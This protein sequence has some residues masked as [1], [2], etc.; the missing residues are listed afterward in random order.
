MDE[1]DERS[2]SRLGWGVL[3]VIAVAAL[4][5]VVYL[6]VLG[7]HGARM[8][9]NYPRLFAFINHRQSDR[10]PAAPVA[11]DRHMDP[12]LESDLRGFVPTST[13][14]TVTVRSGDRETLAFAQEIVAWLRANGWQHVQGVSE[15]QRRE[16]KPLTGTNL[17]VNPKGGMELIIG[18]RSDSAP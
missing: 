11:E 6:A 4:A 9:A 7:L 16:L 8:E 1:S 2:S 5:G 10:A 3:A 14:I 18:P 15:H 17:Q 13:S 12:H